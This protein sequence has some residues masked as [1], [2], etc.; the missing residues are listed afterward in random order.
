MS[1]NQ[2]WGGVARFTWETPASTC[3]V[4]RDILVARPSKLA[5]Y[6]FQKGCFRKSLTVEGDF[7][8]IIDVGKTELCCSTG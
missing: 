8:K 6:W 4:G 2:L 1:R 5:R 7:C 3:L